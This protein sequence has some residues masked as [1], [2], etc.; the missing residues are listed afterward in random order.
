VIPEAIAGYVASLE[1]E[2]GGSVGVYDHRP[3]TAAAPCVYVELESVTYATG[4]LEVA[5]VATAVAD[6]A[7]E[8]GS[9]ALVLNDL[10]DHVVAAAVRGGHIAARLSARPVPA[11]T[12]GDQTYPAVAV[13]GARVTTACALPDPLP[14]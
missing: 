7:R 3:D 4:V 9:Q 13:T 8:P 1:A 12:V 10:V 6:P 14:P 2:L 11:V 5:L